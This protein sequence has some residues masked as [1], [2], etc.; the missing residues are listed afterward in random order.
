[1]IFGPGS[2]G[3]FLY[4]MLCGEVPYGDA[5]ANTLQIMFNHM[6]KPPTPMHTHRQDL[7]EEVVALVMQTLAKDPALRPTAQQLRDAMYQLPW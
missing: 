4:E 7:P 3:R 6:H 2:P 1:M 5:R